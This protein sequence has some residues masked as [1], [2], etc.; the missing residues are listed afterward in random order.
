MLRQLMQVVL[1]T[2][3]LSLLNAQTTQEQYK[4]VVRG[5][6]VDDKG[7]PVPY[8]QTVLH[9]PEPLS[10]WK[11]HDL[12][13]IGEEANAEGRFRYE[14]VTDVPVHDEVLYVTAPPPSNA[15]IGI[16]PPMDEL[17]S[18]NRS[19]AGRP[20][21]VKSNEEM[22]VGDVPVQIRFGVVVV[23]LRNR[24]GAP[25]FTDAESWEGVGVRVRDVRG[26]RVSERYL[27]SASVS[28]AVRVDQSAIA[29]ALPE[30]RW[31][32]EVAPD[33]EEGAWLR[34]DKLLVRA[35]A[36]PLQVSL[37]PSAKRKIKG[38]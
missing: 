30:G 7:R 6:V 8:A 13:I 29:I 37:K 26:K 17:R 2:M 1:S 24:A 38:K 3:L 15:Y 23:H 10:S 22:N 5:R 19:F 28:K 4:Y 16:F 14:G 25:M 18:I 31:S 27:S 9:P 32:I 35:L 11:G 12:L 33:G 20:V 34:S 21:R 36:T